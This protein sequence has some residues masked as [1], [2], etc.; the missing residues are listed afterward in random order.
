MRFASQRY[1]DT[2]STFK[3]AGDNGGLFASIADLAR[4]PV[5]ALDAAVA[6]V[7]ANF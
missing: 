1:D 4:V 2:S 5:I 7:T 3:K 6:S